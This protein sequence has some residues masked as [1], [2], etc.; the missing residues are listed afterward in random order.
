VLFSA[1]LKK[2][3]RYYRL[4]CRPFV[5]SFVYHSIELLMV[6]ATELQVVS[7]ERS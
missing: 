5:R 3:T 7:L 2:K 4:V 1:F 6:A